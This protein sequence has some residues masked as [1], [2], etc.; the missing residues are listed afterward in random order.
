M[1]KSKRKGK[2]HHQNEVI[3]PPQYVY[4]DFCT[5]RVVKHIHPIVNIHREHIQYVPKHEFRPTNRKE[6]V[7]PGY[8]PFCC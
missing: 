4:H 2:H 5:Q 8:R 3:C 6:V 1:G 7:D